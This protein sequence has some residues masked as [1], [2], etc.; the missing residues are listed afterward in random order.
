MDTLRSVQSWAYIVGLVCTLGLVVSGYFAFKSSGRLSELAAQVD[1]QLRDQVQETQ[2]AVNQAELRRQP[3]E[4]QAEQRTAFLGQLQ[5]SESGTIDVESIMGDEEGD[6]YANQFEALFSEAGWNV[7]RARATGNHGIQPG[8]RVIVPDTQAGTV[9][10]QAMT[11]AGV[12]F[13][14]ETAD[15]AEVWIRIGPKP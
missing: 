11:R 3:R 4:L 7:T 14:V 6:A 5:E 9:V 10:V 12:D 1:E 8:V 2:E 15:V 13:Q